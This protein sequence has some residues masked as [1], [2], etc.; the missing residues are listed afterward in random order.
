MVARDAFKLL[1]GWAVEPRSGRFFRNAAIRWA[2]CVASAVGLV[3]L[4]GGC[5]DPKQ[6]PIVYF[7]DG[8]GWY[9]SSGSVAAGLRDAG[10]HGAFRTHS[11][12]ALLGPA[13][14]HLFNASSKGVA[15]GLARRIEKMRRADPNGA[16]NVMGLSAGTA[17]ILSALEQL[18]PGI[19]VN[20]VVLLSPSV[21]A[22]HDLT[23]AMRHVRR[24]LYATSSPHDAILAALVIVNADGK[25]GPTAG[26][27]GFRAPRRASRDTAEAY[28]RVINLPW[29]PNYLAFDWSGGHT[30]V[31]HRKFVASVIA[32]RILSADPFPLDRPIVD[33]FEP[34]PSSPHETDRV[35]AAQL[36]PDRD[37]HKQTSGSAA[38]TQ[39]P[40]GLN[41]GQ[42]GGT[43]R[44]TNSNN[45]SSAEGRR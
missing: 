8:A 5:S 14:D 4:V 35:R 27:V 3:V 20:N 39:S 15:R 7:L 11:W 44:S 34:T 33:R 30:S 2:R 28:S 29:Q 32:P 38:Q 23:K 10:Y 21:S 45:A 36:A 16:I 12:S 24:N 9:S 25:S 1:R 19:E 31:T 18:P 26:R 17:V 22:E 6:G 41:D 43:A 40:L 13:H 42:H 37:V